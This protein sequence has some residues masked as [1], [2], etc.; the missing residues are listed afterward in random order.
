MIIPIIHTNGTSQRELLQQ[1][2]DVRRALTL[3]AEKMSAACP[4]D[5]DYYVS[6]DPQAGHRAHQ[7]HTDRQL[8]LKALIAEYDVLAE[9]VA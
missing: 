9:A 5:R 1:F 3:A 4:H 6:N 2:M 7:E 8:R